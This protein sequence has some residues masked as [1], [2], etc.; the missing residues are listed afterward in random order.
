MADANTWVARLRWVALAITIMTILGALVVIRYPGAWRWIEAIERGLLFAVLAILSVMVLG[1]LLH[2]LGSL[3]RPAVS[4]DAG[5]VVLEL[6]NSRAGSVVLVVVLLIFAAIVAY[7]LDLQTQPGDAFD[8]P[9]PPPTLEWRAVIGF[10]TVVWAFLLVAF[11]VRAVRNPPWFVLTRKGFVYQPGDTSPGLIR[12]EDVVDIKEDRVVSTGGN[13][14][15]APRA[16]LVVVLRD[17]ERYVARYNPILAAVVRFA[18][19]VLRAQTGGRGDVYLDPV[20][21]GARYEEIKA[22]M[23]EHATRVR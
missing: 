3:R 9:V 23:I 12:W 20:H 6:R 17:G 11:T 18:G 1:L 4:A 16:V 2:F 22:L 15:A 10:F 14:A 21:F 7:A 8:P 5:E 19:G 13:G